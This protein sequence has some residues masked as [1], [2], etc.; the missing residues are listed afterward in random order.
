MAKFKQ[1]QN[2][3]SQGMLSPKLRGRTDLAEYF[4]GAEKIVNYLGYKQGGLY[5]RSGSVHV[6]DI[7]FINGDRFEQYTTCFI[8]Y[9]NQVLTYSSDAGKAYLLDTN[10]GAETP[11][12]LGK[13]YDGSSII[14]AS[15]N[16]FD[17]DGTLLQNYLDYAQNGE[18]LF[19]TRPKKVPLVFYKYIDETVGLIPET[20]YKLQLA[21]LPIDQRSK[22]VYD[23]TTTFTKEETLLQPYRA[24]NIVAGKTA[25][26]SATSGLINLQ[27][28]FKIYLELGSL[29][30][31]TQGANT[32]VARIVA[33]SASP[34]GITN[35]Q[36]RVLVNFGSA[37]ASDN[38]QVTSWGSSG[39]LVDLNYPTNVC[40]Y[41]QRLIYSLK[42]TIYG[43][44][45][46]NFQKFMI[47][48]LA[49]DAS[50]NSS[51]LGYFGDTKVT[52]PF[53]FTIASKEFQEIKWLQSGEV[54]EVGTNK[55]EYA[56]YGVQGQILSNEN[57]TIQ[58]Q[59][60]LG[61]AF[62]IPI[63][64]GKDTL[65]IS[66]DRS[67]IRS[68][69]RSDNTT[70]YDAQ[71]IMAL[72]EDIYL[73]ED[74]LD[75]HYQNTTNIVWIRTR[76]KKLKAMTLN[77]VFGI[78]SFV[79][80]EIDGEVWFSTVSGNVL[81]LIVKRNSSWAFLTI[82]KEFKGTELTGS[83][84]TFMDQ[85]I[86]FDQAAS[87]TVSGLS[88][89]NGEEIDVIADGVL[90]EGLSVAGGAVTLPVPV[91]KGCAGLRFSSY[92]QTFNLEAGGNFGTSQGEKKRI[93]ELQ[94]KF[95]RS[96]LGK[97]GSSLSQ[98]YDI[99]GKEYQFASNP[100]TIPLETIDI[101]QKV[102]TRV[103]FNNAVVIGQFR[104]LP[105]NILSIVYKGVTY[106]E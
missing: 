62:N 79:E 3:F 30:K 21:T 13:E 9:N 89:L 44:L 65:Y 85:S 25:T 104:S 84:F 78:R 96:Y 76:D 53:E 40:F 57:V 17:E 8:P 77:R 7:E 102:D 43:S 41:E 56:V 73:G 31:I 95:Y 80:I 29:V 55:G 49:Q 12:I 54:L 72:S 48:R 75:L 27:F 99:S 58:Q 64:A 67:S 4:Q 32:G 18:L 16:I 39:Q 101:D 1:I 98:L 42:E 90:Y 34:A 38:W 69:I 88:H 83:D 94:I 22:V 26:P 86:N 20:G 10:S 82:D 106:E 19:I 71:E 35:Y 46:G 50:T 33:A 24:P 28:N 37:T 97:I 74:I 5:R 11:I 66:N 68:F 45:T 15:G 36:A 100:S 91:Q 105:S 2:T 93:N 59:S 47:R 60:N 51:G 63:K 103:S 92:I 52:D 23:P 81:C 61:G 87:T 14:L 6:K 70:T